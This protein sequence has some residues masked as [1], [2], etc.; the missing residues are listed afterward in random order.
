MEQMCAKPRAFGVDLPSPTMDN[1]ESYATTR[2]A[3]LELATTL[4][5]DDATRP[6]PALPG[7][8]VKDAYAH[9]AGVCADVLDGRLSG[10]GSPEW[11]AQQVDDRVDLLLAEVTDEWAARGPVLDDMIRSRPARET[12][13]LAFDVWSHEQD[14]RAAVGL[15]GVR[16]DDRVTFLVEI[17]C[18]RFDGRFRE[19]GAPALLLLRPSGDRVLGEGPPGASL[20]VDDYELLRLFFGR[21]SIDQIGR[22]AWHGD[23]APY[24]DHL[25]IFPL[26][27]TDLDD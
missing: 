15:R 19:S 10:V 16:D 27:V 14:I 18:D 5:P 9:L 20:R 6:V 17:A 22:A 8:T 11:T 3:L 1:A 4:G 13:L 23:P 24:V 21:R 26:P 2:A 12:S 25:H 7:W